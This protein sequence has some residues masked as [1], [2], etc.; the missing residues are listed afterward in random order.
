MPPVNHVGYY[1]APAPFLS[2]LSVRFRSPPSLEDRGPRHVVSCT[3]AFRA[4]SMALKL[5][6]TYDT[7]AE[8]EKAF[9]EF[10]VRNHVLFVTKATKTVQVVNSRLTPGLER[11]KE[12]LKYANA[13]YVCKHGGSARTTGTGIRPHQR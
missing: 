6:A 10:Q 1:C 4:T 3:Y 13:T 9:V 8:F 2:A 7:F 5:N 12:E 11:L